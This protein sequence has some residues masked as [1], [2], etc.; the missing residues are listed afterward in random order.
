M[1]VILVINLDDISRIDS[2]TFVSYLCWSLSGVSG[3]QEVF[4]AHHLSKTRGRLGP[5]CGAMG[6]Y[7]CVEAG[8][9]SAGHEFVELLV[10][11]TQEEEG[12]HL[13]HEEGRWSEGTSSW[14]QKGWISDLSAAV[15][16]VCSWSWSSLRLISGSNL[17]S[18]QACGGDSNEQPEEPKFKTCFL[19]IITRKW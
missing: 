17:Y 4:F 2:N 1:L 11:D 6:R 12:H 8:L 5:L 18:I 9:R 16:V 15:R 3:S 7:F 19:L 10:Q 14:R 13:S